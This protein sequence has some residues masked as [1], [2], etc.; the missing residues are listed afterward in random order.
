VHPSDSSLARGLHGEYNELM[1]G[2]AV[3]ADE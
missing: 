1:G 2:K 3:G